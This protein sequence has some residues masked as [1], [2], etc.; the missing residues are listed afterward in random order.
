MRYS[1]LLKG[2]DRI[3]T[4]FEGDRSEAV[5]HLYVI[6]TTER[7]DLK[8]Y[9][10]KRQIDTG[11]HYPLPLHRQKAYESLYQENNNLTVSEQVA[12]EILSLPMFPGL[13]EEQ[14]RQ[15][16]EGFR[17]FSSTPR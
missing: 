14:Q 4:P 3:V 9:L 7:D 8:K 1:D 12:R 15:V 16:A 11:L 17:A 6:R 10:A 13:T 2:L 5:Y